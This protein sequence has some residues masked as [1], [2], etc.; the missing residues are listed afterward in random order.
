[1]KS[2]SIYLIRHG[3]TKGN[4]EARYIGHTDEP[5]SDEGKAQIKKMK[6]DYDYPETQ[7]VFSSPLS[8]CTE[9]SKIIY[10]G[11]E[12]IEMEGLIEYNFGEFEGKTAAELEN[13]PVFADWLAGKK[14]VEAPFGESNETFGKRIAQTFIKIVDGLLKTGTRS[15]A[16]VTHGGVLSALMSFFA[17]PEAQIHEWAVP[18][19]CGYE[20][21]VIPSL[22]SQGKKLE[23]VAQIP[24]VPG[25]RDEDYVSA[26]EFDSDFN[27]E[28]YLYD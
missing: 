23:A 8:R 26:D 13:H 24:Y 3:L 5:L 10:P 22:W 16:I 4:T 7:I 25:E 6:E 18:G 27:V 9:T 28:D 14:G 17:L 11:I 19:G 12:P 15:C 21:R 2:Y 1:M 20:L